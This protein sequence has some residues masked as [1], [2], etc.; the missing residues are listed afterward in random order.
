LF[1]RLLRITERQI[2]MHQATLRQ[3]AKYFSEIT[4]SGDLFLDAD[5]GIATGVRKDCHHVMPAEIGRLL[6]AADNRLVISYQHVRGKRVRDRIDEVVGAL[7]HEIGE[8][9]WC[10]YESPTVA[11]LF[12]GRT[13]ERTTPVVEHFET[14]LG[15]HAVHRVRAGG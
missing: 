7:H 9:S 15:G 4:H 13:C 3:R 2:L 1:A 8:F 10:S 11:L 14:F 12:L 5:T 6:E